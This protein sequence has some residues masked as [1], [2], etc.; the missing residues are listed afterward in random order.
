MNHTPAWFNSVQGCQKYSRSG[1]IFNLLMVYHL[2]RL[3][4]LRDRIILC[5]HSQLVWFDNQRHID[6]M[7]LRLGFRGFAQHQ[8]VQGRIVNPNSTITTEASTQQV[9]SM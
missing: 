8:N 7:H 2:P 5:N 6:L 1:L 3:F 9:E 4:F